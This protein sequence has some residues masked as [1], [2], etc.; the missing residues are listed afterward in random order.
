MKKRANERIG[1]DEHKAQDI[2]LSNAG[3]IN[4]QSIIPIKEEETEVERI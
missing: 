2:V 3:E 1:L 4:I